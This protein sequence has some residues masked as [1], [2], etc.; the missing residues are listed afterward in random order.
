VTTDTYLDNLQ[1]TQILTTADDVSAMVQ[2]FGTGDVLGW[3]F[4]TTGLDYIRSD[5][6]GI[7][8]ANNDR[9]WYLTGQAMFASVPWLINK[10]SDP[11]IKS[12]GH[13]VLF[14]LHFLKKL[15]GP[16]KMFRPANMIDTIIA[17]FLVNENVGL[18]LKSLAAN[19]FAIPKELLPDYKD[20]MRET[21]SA[22]MYPRLD[23]VSIFDMDLEKL[24]IYAGRDA[25]LPIR[26]WEGL[27]SEL[28]R[29]EQHEHFLDIEMP[30]VWVLWKMEQNGMYLLPERLSELEEDLV[31]KHTQWLERWKTLTKDNDKYPEGRNPNSNPQMQEWFYDIQKHKADRET[32]KGAPS[33]DGIMVQRMMHAGDASAEAL[34][35]IRQYEKLLNTYVIK[36]RAQML[37]SQYIHGSFNQTGT[38]TMRLSASDP[39]LQ[40]IPARTEEGA[41]IRTAFGA[42]PGYTVLDVD[43]SQ[44]ELRMLAH[45]SKAAALI[46]VFE[47]PDGDPHQLTADLVMV[48]RRIGKTLNFA[49]AFGAG[50]RKLCDIIE[51]EGY[52]RP[53]ETD[54]KKWMRGFEQ[55]YPELVNWKDRVLKYS[56]QLGY[57]KTIAQRRRHL[58]DLNHYDRKYRGTAERQAVN[59]IIQGSAGD[60]LKWA[61]LEISK[62]TDFYGARMQVQ[63]HDELV[64]I[65]PEQAAKEFSIVVKSKLEQVREVFNISVPIVADPGIGP[66]WGDAKH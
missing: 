50:P 9:A 63:V 52:P 51:K 30:F 7:A 12:I 35:N 45:Y 26:M 64:F 21:K 43:Y 61:M 36:L 42:P 57:V 29:E 54:A 10:M 39:N 32:K 17:Q 11:N 33:V 15:V 24:G 56:R 44:I 48:E 4:E 38:V 27:E 28:K 16:G 13:N 47:D 34:F 66:T 40:N 6:H 19:R 41:K 46:K 25:W 8:I 23:Q 20:L 53:L 55:A 65:V 22:K 14:D 1:S 2:N 3:D 31:A 59:S 5:P 37:P 18:G 58:P 49:W 60:V 62:L